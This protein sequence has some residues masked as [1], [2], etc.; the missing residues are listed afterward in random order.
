MKKIPKEFRNKV[1]KCYPED[2]RVD[3]TSAAVSA[4]EMPCISKEV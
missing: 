2:D 1:K 3:K 4:E